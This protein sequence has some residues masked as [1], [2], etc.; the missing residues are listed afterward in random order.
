MPCTKDNI[1]MKSITV[2]KISFDFVLDYHVSERMLPSIYTGKV[3]PVSESC[4]TFP[5]FI[6]GIFLVSDQ[7]FC[8]GTTHLHNSSNFPVNSQCLM[9]H[10]GNLV[11]IYHNIP[12]IHTGKYSQCLITHFVPVNLLCVFHQNSQQIP[13]FFWPFPL[14]LTIAWDRQHCDSRL[15]IPLVLTGTSQNIPRIFLW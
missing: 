7:T 4:I 15:E 11:G 9:G 12:S 14:F 1:G 6:L 8:A 3:F 10:W 13:S 5:V 2:M